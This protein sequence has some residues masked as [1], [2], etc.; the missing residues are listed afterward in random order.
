M[1][2]DIEKDT[3]YIGLKGFSRYS[4]E[5]SY[6]IDEINSLCREKEVFVALN[7]VKEADEVMG[8]MEKINAK[9][10]ILND[11]GTIREAKKRFPDRVIVASV[12]LNILNELD[13]QFYGDIGADIVVIPPELNDELKEDLGWQLPQ[14]KPNQKRP[15]IER[16]KFALVEMFYK[17]KCYLNAFF[18]GKSTKK[19]GVC[20]KLCSRRW[21][22]KVILNDTDG[23]DVAILKFAPQPKEFDV[24][25]EYLKIEGRQLRKTQKKAR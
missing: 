19:D 18:I 11:A 1:S 3:I 16:F 9:G 20:G 6:T 15:K 17:G 2:P 22:V 5:F 4:D 23:K 25:A 8:V 12:G 21:K 24:S 7:R 10:F 14:I 13:V